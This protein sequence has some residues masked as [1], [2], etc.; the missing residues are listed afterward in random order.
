MP[1]LGLTL[2]LTILYSVFFGFDAKSKPF[3]TESSWGFLTTSKATLYLI[4]AVPKA[5]MM[6]CAVITVSSILIDIDVC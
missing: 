2:I 6:K 1:S 3:F 5:L 4:L